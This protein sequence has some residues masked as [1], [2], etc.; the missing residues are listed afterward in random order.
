MV[1]ALVLRS[2][3]LVA[4]FRVALVVAFAALVCALLLFA[5]LVTLPGRLADVVTDG[6]RP[7]VRR[8][9]DVLLTVVLVDLLDPD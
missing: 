1:P 7:S 6:A 3:H 4:V 5:C 8:R 2:P 9:L